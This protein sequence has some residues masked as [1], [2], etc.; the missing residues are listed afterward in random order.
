MDTEVKLHHK[1]P[2][3]MSMYSKSSEEL[4]YTKCRFES[5]SGEERMFIWFQNA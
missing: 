3:N 4:A 5:Y 2:W 1:A